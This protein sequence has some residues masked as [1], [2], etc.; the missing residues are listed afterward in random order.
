MV[1]IILSTLVLALAVVFVACGGEN[2]GN[3]GS[4]DGDTDSDSDS[5]A[6]SDTDTHTDTDTYTDTDTNSESDTDTNC[7]PGESQCQ[8]GS[9]SWCN[10]NREWVETSCSSTIYSP[11]NCA[12]SDP[13]NWQNDNDCD[14][15]CL[16]VPGVNQ[17]FNDNKDCGYDTDPDPDTDTNTN[18]DTGPGSCDGATVGNYCWYL[19]EEDE[20]C[21]DTCKSHGGY[22]EA[23]RTYAGSEGSDAKCEDVLA[24]LGKPG[25]VDPTASEFNVGCHYSESDSKGYRDAMGKTTADAELDLRACACNQ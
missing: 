16:E 6:D 1:K 7:T 2:S 8:G 3:S 10:E 21:T 11:C 18:T 23:T 24:A 22:N 17:M 19:S 4:S 14:D 9:G 15:G 25:N 13:C 5:D 12:V 20:S